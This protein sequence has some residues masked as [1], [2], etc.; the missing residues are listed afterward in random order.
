MAHVQPHLLR[1]P[2]HVQPRVPKAP[3][4]FAPEVVSR[5]KALKVARD[6]IHEGYPPVLVFATLQN[7]RCE[8]LHERID[9]YL[10]AKQD[11]D[12]LLDEGAIL[13]PE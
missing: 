2:A 4:D 12:L 7:I 1:P 6:L 3:P 8:G 10:A 13:P 5:A 9:V 11:M